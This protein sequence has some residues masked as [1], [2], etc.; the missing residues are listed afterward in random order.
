L[1]E[2]PNWLILITGI[3]VH[4]LIHG[5]V[6]INYSENGLKSIK[7]GVSWETLTPYCH[8]KEPM[9]L[10]NYRRILYSRGIILGV[11]PLLI[12]MLAGHNELFL[13]GFLFTLAAAGDFLMIWKLKNE[14]KDTLIF[15]HPSKLGCYLLSSESSANEDKNQKTNDK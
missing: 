3:I 14:D 1:R 9:K 7:L 10:I 4:E 2:F 13:F 11:I 6:T 15:D 12:G 5:L 8:S